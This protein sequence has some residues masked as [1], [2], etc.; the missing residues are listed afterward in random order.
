MRRVKLLPAITCTLLFTS[1]SSLGADK[2]VIAHRGASGYLPEHT[3]AAVSLAYG[4]RADYIEQDV[5]LSKDRQP[6]VLHDVHIDTVTDVSAKFPTRRRS[7]GRFYAI[8]FTLAELQTLSVNER[9]DAKT[10]KPVFPA[11]FPQKLSRFRIATLEEE[12]ELI[13]GLNQ[14]TQ[15]SVGIY[16]EIKSPAW[17]REHGYDISKV[18][19]AMLQK[20]GYATIDDACFL[21]CFDQ[22]E[23]I[24]VR[25]E[26][27]IKLRLVQL[28]GDEPEHRTQAGLKKIASYANGIGP[29]LSAVFNENG[30]TTSLIE[31]AHEAGLKV[32]PYT[33]RVDALSSGFQDANGL[34][35]AIF[36]TANAD[37]VFSDFPDV[38]VEY[39]KPQA[40]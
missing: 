37:G 9:V 12:L 36:E 39:L 18:V 32:H 7:D 31:M 6:I 4:M 33:F 26:L 1:L 27:G 8:D 24:R 14:S 22:E 38:C 35:R 17:H 11:R 16:P 3:L 20:H 30:K 23:L 13:R 19:V 34:L 10:G 29:S 21:Q 5:V 25:H 2:L 15:R 40:R 28:M